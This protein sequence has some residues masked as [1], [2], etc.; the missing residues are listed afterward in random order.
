MNM[1]T[2]FL[3][4]GIPGLHL[5]GFGFPPQDGPPANGESYRNMATVPFRM[6][7]PHSFKTMLLVDCPYTEVPKRMEPMMFN[8]QDIQGVLDNIK[9]ELPGLVGDAVDSRLAI[10]LNAQQAT[11]T[12][13]IVE[14]KE[15]VLA[16]E[17]KASVV[18]LNGS[19]FGFGKIT[20][21]FSKS[22]ELL[23]SIGGAW[24]GLSQVGSNVDNVSFP[25]QLGR[26]AL[27]GA[28]GTMKIGAAGLGAAVVMSALLATTG[29]ALNKTHEAFPSVPSASAVVS[30][31]TGQAEK[32]KVGVGAFEVEKA[33]SEV[34]TLSVQERAAALLEQN[35]NNYGKAIESVH[36]A[37]GNS[38]MNDA[39]VETIAKQKQLLTT[40]QGM[41]SQ[42][43]VAVAHS[44]ST[45]GL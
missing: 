31:I 38:Y 29:I 18:T 30:A 8:S 4:H 17:S 21:A 23:Q 39:S 19:V 2:H 24:R 26:A 35:G 13:Q 37:L 16:K 44:A 6:G 15:A 9:K 28:R 12:T 25:R 10:R 36:A 27:G 33:G 43:P 1:S 41:Q 20:E 42:V 7:S 45:P 5:T 3:H 22:V 34:K 40:L 32:I 11:L 14:A